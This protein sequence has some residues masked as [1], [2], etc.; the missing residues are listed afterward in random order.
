MAFELEGRILTKLG[1]QSGTS[2]RGAWARQDF[3]L[4]YQDGNYPAQACITAWGEEA[5]RELDRHG[6]GETVRV[7]FNVKAREYNG[8]W[9]NDLR[10]W[11]FLAPAGAAPDAAA[12]RPA[13]AAPGHA[14]P[15]AA[16]PAPGIEDMPAEP[17]EDD[18]PF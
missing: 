9:F 14:A 1:A 17:S 3:V 6:V 18:L 8:R 13:A 4:E 12:A 15:A 10:L 2:A 5:V 16:A 11:R 7:S